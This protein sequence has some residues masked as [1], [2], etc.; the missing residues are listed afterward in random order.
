[1]NPCWRW[2]SLDHHTWNLWMPQRTCRLANAKVLIVPHVINPMKVEDCRPG[3]PGPSKN[4]CAKGK[5]ASSIDLAVQKIW[6]TWR[7]VFYQLC[8]IS[9]KREPTCCTNLGWIGSTG[10]R[11][12]HYRSFKASY[13]FLRQE[14]QSSSHVKKV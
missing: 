13:S 3:G 5:A 8:A 9:K 11:F 10:G 12:L 1:M 7:N 4:S 6:K 2:K 14:L